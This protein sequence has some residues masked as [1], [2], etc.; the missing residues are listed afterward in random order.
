MAKKRTAAKASPT[1]AAIANKKKKLVKEAAN[2]KD[3]RFEND[4]IPDGVYVA[5]VSFEV[6]VTKDGT[7]WYAYNVTIARDEQKNKRCRMWN[8]LTDQFKYQ[9]GKRTDEIRRSEQEQWEQFFRDLR[10]AGIEDVE[11]LDPE[12]I[13]EVCL[14]TREEPL[15][16][17]VKISNWEGERSS[18]MNCYINRPIG[19]DENE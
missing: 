13:E 18:G 4:D 3:S 14:D 15:V 16:C 1:F 2:A 7:P 11:N 10:H 5:K 8:S 12:Q 19:E 6:G 17:Q 9:D